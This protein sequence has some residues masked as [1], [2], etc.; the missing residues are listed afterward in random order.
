MLDLSE[1]DKNHNDLPCVLFDTKE[2]FIHLE[3]MKHDRGYWAILSKRCS[4][5]EV[6]RAN[7]GSVSTEEQINA[8]T[9]AFELLS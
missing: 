2:G 7:I 8:L 9:D 1:L 5:E 3:F 4:G 6:F